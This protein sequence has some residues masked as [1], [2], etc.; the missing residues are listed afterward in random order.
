M[1]SSS[2]TPVKYRYRRVLRRAR[3]ASPLRARVTTL[4]RRHTSAHPR[5]RKRH[6]TLC[7]LPVIRTSSNRDNDSD[8]STPSHHVHYYRTS[9]PPHDRRWERDDQGEWRFDLR[10]HTER[11]GYVRRDYTRPRVDYESWT[12][13]EYSSFSS[14]DEYTQ[15]SSDDECAYWRSDDEW[16]DHLQIRKEKRKTNHRLEGRSSYRPMLVVEERRPRSLSPY[17]H[18]EVVR[19]VI[20][21]RVYPPFV[22]PSGR[23]R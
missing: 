15:S 12:D 6:V 18:V 10:R 22:R 9:A 7:R 2:S 14:D 4:T 11:T 23:R 17:R 3:S 1:S 5:S 13:E 16:E 21:D 8:D 20:R 19:P